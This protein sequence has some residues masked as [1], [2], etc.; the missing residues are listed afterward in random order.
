MDRTTAQRIAS[1][2]RRPALRLAYSKPPSAWYRLRARTRRLVRDGIV[3]EAALVTLTLALVGLLLL[4]LY[5]AQAG[6][7]PLP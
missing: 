5:R 1:A 4:L 7:V 2:G 6:Y 3:A